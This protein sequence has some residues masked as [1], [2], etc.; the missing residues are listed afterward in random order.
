MIKISALKTFTGQRHRYSSEPEMTRGRIILLT[1]RLPFITGNDAL[2]QLTRRNVSLYISI[3][4]L[5][6]S[7]FYKEYPNFSIESEATKYKL[8][9]EGT[10]TG[11]LGKYFSIFP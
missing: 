3:T 7:S 10:P 5:N 1:S 11:T 8:H 2:H 4:S 6:G 9:I